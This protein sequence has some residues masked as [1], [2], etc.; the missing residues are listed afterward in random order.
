MKS[1]AVNRSALAVEG[2]RD[3]TAVVRDLDKRQAALAGH[4]VDVEA[5]APL[6][7]ARLEERDSQVVVLPGFYGRN[8]A[9][10]IQLMGRNGTDYTAACMAAASG[11][12][13]CQI[14]KDVD[15]VR[16]ADP[17]L[18]PGARPI[19]AMS[20]R[21]LRELA[22]MGATV[23]HEEAIFPVRAAGIPVNI[24][25]TNHPEHPGTLIVPGDRAE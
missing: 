12:G 14:W 22:Y 7:K 2:G 23:L 10:K 18:V 6:V 21:E 1:K 20:Y 3:D 24:R 8:A 9:G 19:R 4:L 11:A 5:A 25:D 17:R 16:T 15:G 13:L